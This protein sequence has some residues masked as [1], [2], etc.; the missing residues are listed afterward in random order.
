MTPDVNS[1]EGFVS[2]SSVGS[3]SWEEVEISLV[4]E[5]EA[6]KNGKEEE[7]N[8]S[9]KSGVSERREREGRGKE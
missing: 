3:K 4:K 1:Q 8:V 5:D 2:A 7:V 9:G 6:G